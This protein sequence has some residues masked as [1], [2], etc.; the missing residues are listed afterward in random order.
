MAVGFYGLALGNYFIALV[1]LTMALER[2]FIAIEG[3]FILI[4]YLIMTS[5]SEKTFGARLQNAQFLL[6]YIQNLVDFNPPQATESSAIFKSFID[7]I[8]VSN[9]VESEL[10]QNYKAAVSA[11]KD[12]FRSKG[13][14][15]SKLLP[16]IRGAVVAAYGKKSQQAEAIGLI[17]GKMQSVKLDAPPALPKNP[18]LSN[19]Q[20]PVPNK[21]LS[22]TISVSQQSYGSL[23]KFFN[24]LINTLVQFA[25]YNPSNIDLQINNLKAFA[26]VLNNLNIAVADTY[27]KLVVERKKRLAMYAD[28]SER[29]QRIKSYIKSQ[30]GTSSESFGLVK[31]LTV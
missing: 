13:K 28:L 3:G 23:T 29:V 20:L 7:E 18:V 17:I 2:R 8:I 4:I 15:L 25:N 22:Q 9:T 11:R 16:L 19:G 30:Y 21:T 1:T 31:S 5:N 24:D 26:Q 12:A 10:T 6:T 27:Q 14:S